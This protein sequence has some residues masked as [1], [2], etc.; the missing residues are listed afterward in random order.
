[1]RGL[2]QKV[3]LAAVLA[4]AG[5]AAG[6]GAY[7]D[8]SVTI[9]SAAVFDPARYAGAWYEIASYPVPFQSGCT[10][11]LAEYGVLPDGSLS[12][13]NSCRVDG[14]LR[15]IEGD[16]RIV[17]PGRLE[18]SFD[19][20]PFLSAPYWVLWVSDDYRTAVVGVPSG[21]A[22]WILNR[23]PAIS[24]DRLAAAREVLDFNGYDLS[25]LVMTPQTNPIAP[26]L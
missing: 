7:R 26:A 25:R 16:A 2:T 17:G 24:A 19:T 13:T 9:A 14:R 11:T 21:R 15:R 12:V 20:V 10:D 1:M 4:V 22:G 6:T 18:V 8:T 3:A 5:C 23:D